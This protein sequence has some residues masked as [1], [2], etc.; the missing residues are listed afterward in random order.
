MIGSNSLEQP[1]RYSKHCS[2]LLTQVDHYQPLLAQPETHLTLAMISIIVS[3]LP[4]NKTSNVAELFDN[5]SQNVK[6]KRYSEA[7]V[8]IK[9]TIERHTSLFHKPFH[10]ASILRQL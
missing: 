8:D 7:L 1:L 9:A 2:S 6:V 5:V 10:R 4:V 3:S